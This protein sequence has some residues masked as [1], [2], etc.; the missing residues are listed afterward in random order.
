MSIITSI[1]YGFIQGVAEFLP[2]S[3]SAHLALLPRMLNVSDPGQFFDLSL[4]LGTGLSILVF[5]YR[6]I[7]LILKDFFYFITFQKAKLSPTYFLMKNLLVGTIATF[8]MVIL[9]KKFGPNDL[10]S[11]SLMAF[12]TIF[13]GIVMG[14]T[15][16]FSKKEKKEI[17]G[18]DQKKK[19]LFIG[20]CQGLAMIPGV[21]RLGA[22]MT[23]SRVF[24]ISRTESA[25]YSFLLSL[26]VVFGGFLIELKDLPAGQEFYFFPILIGGIISFIMGLITLNLFMKWVEKI[27]LV[28]FSVYRIL[29]GLFLLF[30]NSSTI[31]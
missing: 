27:G 1:I 2:I 9:L 4:H 17:M 30:G 19:S 16:Y 5:F 20:L 15:D 10:R 7:L 13:F 29:F 25:K 14:I 23:M 24:G 11:V 21:S 3:S 8:F 22:T 31:S 12:N 28:P 18:M 6:E 26:P